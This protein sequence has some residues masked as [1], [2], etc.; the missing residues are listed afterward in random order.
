[1]TGD[2]SLEKTSAKRIVQRFV[3]IGPG[4]SI[5]VCLAIGLP[6]SFSSGFFLPG[7][8]LP[9]P[10][11]PWILLARI[12]ISDQEGERK[13]GSMGREDKGTDSPTELVKLCS[14][15]SQ[16][17]THGSCLRNWKALEETVL[18]WRL[19]AYE[20]P[21]SDRPRIGGGRELL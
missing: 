12:V 2:W 10:L 13:H 6:W 15:R 3:R 5:H 18:L 14:V 8:E 21:L 1:V 17:A 9:K 4:P 19:L 7:V 11:L 16:H 20:C